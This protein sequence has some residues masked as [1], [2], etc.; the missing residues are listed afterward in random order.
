MKIL[1]TGGGTG[2]HI[3]PI[4]AIVRQL[5]KLSLPKEQAKP[6]SLFYMGP[7]DRL[8]ASLLK[9]EGVR[10]K[11]VLSGKVRRYLTPLAFLE[12]LFDLFI[13]LPLGIFQAFFLLFF[14][15]PDVIFSKGGYGSLP[16]VFAGWLL[17]IPIF[18]HE[19]DA[20]PGLA[21]RL[22]APLSTDIFISFPRSEKSPPQKGL[23][24]GNPIR[25]SILMGSA[26]EGKK[27][28]QLSG[29]KPVIL[30]TGGSQGATRI[31][32]LVLNILPEWLKHFELIHIT[33]PDHIEDIKKESGVLLSKKLKRYYH[34]VAFLEEERLA[35]AYQACHLIVARAGAGSIFEIA[36]LGKPNILLPLPEAAQDHQRKN[37]YM[38]AEA[39]GAI[40]I[41]QAN[42]TP[43]FL[44][45]KIRQLFAQPDD[46]KKLAQQ[47]LKFSKPRAAEIIAEYLIAY[48][49]A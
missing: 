7:S 6:V 27:I 38:M 49:T 16:V 9:K 42:L 8:A 21:N 22:A 45:E 25:E 40:V 23:V 2:G 30:I 10:V 24:V 15:A 19:S 28:F 32:D 46:F 17:R 12:N 14:L 37:A 44:L 13:K 36:A 20:V 3:F 4:L 18:L 5:K 48:L 31:N 35:H 34:P 43:H 26:E 47:A 39:G 1:F 29:E 11:T 33:G 41:E